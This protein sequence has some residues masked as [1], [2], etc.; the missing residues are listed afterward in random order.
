[1]ALQTTGA[2]SFS[3]MQTE[4]GGSNPISMTEYYGKS[5][6]PSS[7]TISASDFYGTADA[8]STTYKG[9]SSS[10]TVSGSGI[11]VCAGMTTGSFSN[12]P[13]LTSVVVTGCTALTL[14]TYLLCVVTLQYQAQAATQSLLRVM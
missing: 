2:I 6:L 12:P 13:N 14:L 1:M 10:F 7:G 9:T 8:I 3:D 11:I 4:F 5:T